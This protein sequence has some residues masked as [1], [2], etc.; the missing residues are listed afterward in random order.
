MFTDRI[1]F[2]FE[3]HVG[4]ESFAFPDEHL[5]EARHDGFRPF[6]RNGLVDGHFAPAQDRLSFILHDLL[7]HQDLFF[8]EFVVFVGEDHPDAVLA[9]LREIESQD[10]AFP[11]EK[12]MGKLKQ[13]PG[14]VAGVFIRPLRPA[15]A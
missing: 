15:M 11:F 9:G 5:D 4:S 8:P 6:A 2:P 1:E 10:L 7:E 14:A 12:C 13:D 3:F